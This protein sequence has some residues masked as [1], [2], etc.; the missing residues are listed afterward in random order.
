MHD[1][2]VTSVREPHASAN[3]ILASTVLRKIL[4]RQPFTDGK[5]KGGWKRKGKRKKGKGDASR[6]TDTRFSGEWKA[7]SL[8]SGA[9]RKGATKEIT[10]SQDTIERENKKE[11]REKEKWRTGHARLAQAGPRQSRR[12][13]GEK[14]TR[15]PGLCARLHSGW[16]SVG[17]VDRLLADLVACALAL[18]TAV[19]QATRK[20]TALSRDFSAQKTFWRGCQPGYLVRCTPD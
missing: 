13:Q 10:E 9:E 19:Q 15:N 12:F 18:P 17:R 6:K 3:L 8:E 11:R 1:Q 14:P 2:A 5:G 4:C 16:L 7:A 20:W